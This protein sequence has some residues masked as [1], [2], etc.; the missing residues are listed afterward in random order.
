MQ[1]A[2]ASNRVEIA[3]PWNDYGRMQAEYA[4]MEQE[5]YKQGGKEAVRVLW[6]TLGR[7]DLFFLLTRLL[8][9]K[10]LNHPWLFA[11]CREVQA[12]PDGYLD[13]WA[14][15]HGKSSLITFGQTIRDILLHPEVTVGIFSHTRPVAKDFL[16]QIKYEFE[17]NSQLKSCYP[18]VLWKNPRREAPVW[19]LDKGI[20]VKRK[21]NP[22]EA[23]VEAWG[24]VDGQPTGKHFS[25]MVYDDVVTRE[26]V[27]TPEMIAKVTDAWALSL[28]LGARGG[29]RRYIGTRYHRNDTYQT[30][31]ERG[32]AKARIYPA[33]ENGHADGPP[34]LLSATALAEK[35]KSMG[36]HVFGCQM[37][38]NPRADLARGFREAWLRYWNPEG[39]CE[40]MNRYIVVDPANSRK[41]GSDYTVMLVLCLGADHNWYV[42]D[43][44]RSH[45]GL[46][47]RAET[48]FRLHRKHVPLAV[49]YEQYGMQADIEYILT[50][51]ERLNYRF[52]IIPLGGSIPKRD[53]ILALAP[54]FEQGRIY[55][56]NR[57]PFVG[58]EGTWR[59]LTKD[60]V[61]EF[62]SYPVCNHDDAL[63]CLA[64]ILDPKLEAHFPAAF[65]AELAAGEAIME[66]DMFGGG[67]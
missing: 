34:V 6:A 66:Y 38:L 24:L 25:L 20:V 7:G 61:E 41:K 64:R 31:L 36:V 8:R 67:R 53:R 12:G 58:A 43:G 5:A 47:E 49:G 39:A 63:D 42:A 22:K 3:A 28:N 59:D 15:E 21:G 9:R 54:Y 45:L 10:D 56:P 57:C 51:Q 37:L 4:R 18:E 29:R 19:S 13:L 46:K 26:S 27:S 48:L 30:M 44:V 14:R 52:P 2:Q 33:T 35:R 60:I 16:G 50:E 65:G 40:G 1:K 32:A 17:Q 55:L 23:T 11:R 62:L